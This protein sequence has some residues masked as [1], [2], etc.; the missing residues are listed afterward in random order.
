MPTTSG[1]LSD[2]PAYF[3]EWMKHFE[4]RGEKMN[5]EAFLLQEILATLR[6]MEALLKKSG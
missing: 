3:M 2:D 6:R 5:K 4:A 1:D